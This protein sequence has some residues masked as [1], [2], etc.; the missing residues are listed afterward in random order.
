MYETEDVI[1]YAILLQE[2]KYIYLFI[3][4]VGIVSSLQYPCWC[5]KPKAKE[6]VIKCKTK[7]SNTIDSMA[8]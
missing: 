3:D 5:T 2:E 4:L 6:M 7:S 1:T 8:S